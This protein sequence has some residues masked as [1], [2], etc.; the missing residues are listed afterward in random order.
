MLSLTLEGRVFAQDK[1]GLDDRI[2]ASTFKG[3][4]KAFVASSDIK[5]LKKDGIAKLEKMDEEK[6]KARYRKVFAVIKN[7]PPMLRLQYGITENL[8]PQQA[9]VNIRLL[10]KN[11]IY[12]AIDAVPDAVIAAEFKRY[13]YQKEQGVKNSPTIESINKL[14]NRII[15]RSSNGSGKVKK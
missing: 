15:A 1:L 11:R 13:L 12:E 9:I 2:I 4:A 5:K 7:L 14:W 3:L 8:P 10:D 6:F